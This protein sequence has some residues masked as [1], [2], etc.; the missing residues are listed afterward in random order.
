MW[1]PSAEG[2]WNEAPRVVGCGE[3]DTL[4]L[5]TAKTIATSIVHS[6]LDYCNSLY[7]YNGLPKYQI[8]SIQHIQNALARTR[9]QNSNTSLLFWNLFTGLKFLNGL[10]IG[11]K[12]FLSQNSQYHSSTACLWPCIYSV[13]S[14]SQHTLFTLCHSD[15]T[16]IIAQS[17]SPL[18]PTCFT[19]SLEPAS[20]IT[21]NSSSKLFIPLSAT[22]ILDMPV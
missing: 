14:W 20:Y 2:G 8:N 21:Q 16:T 5:H 11:L 13:S 19:S 12:S 10:N 9:L 6:K 15:Q 3:G 7:I 18:L 17:H 4:N 1:S 22:F